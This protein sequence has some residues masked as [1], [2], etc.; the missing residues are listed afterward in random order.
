MLFRSRPSTSPLTFSRT[1]FGAAR[2]VLLGALALAATACAKQAEGER[3]D[4]LSGS[5]D[6]EDGLTCKPLDQLRSGAEGAVCCSD[7]PSVNICRSS[8]F[9]LP[10]GGTPSDAPTASDAGAASGVSSGPGSSSSNGQDVDA[11]AEAGASDPSAPLSSSSSTSTGAE[12]S[13]EPVSDALSSD[14]LSSNTSPDA[15]PTAV[16]SSETADAAVPDAAL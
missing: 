9:N 2:T 1:R 5:Q 6:C 10:D 13:S 8:T 14:P 15:A 4:P 11:S 3:C 16:S 7:N 12:V